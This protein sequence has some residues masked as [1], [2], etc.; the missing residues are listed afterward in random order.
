MDQLSNL[1][2]ASQQLLPTPAT[3]CR[4]LPVTTALR[5]RE[6]KPRGPL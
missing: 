2:V 4:E 6:P 1:N 3:I 5:Y